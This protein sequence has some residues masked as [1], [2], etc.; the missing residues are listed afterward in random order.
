MNMITQIFKSSLGKKYI[1]AVTGFIL[2]LFV[3]GHLAGNLQI[4]LGREAINRYGHFLQS[5]PELIWPARIVLLLMVALHIWAAAKLSM[6]NKAARPVAYE[7]YVPTGSTYASRTMLMSGTIIFVFIIYHLLHFTVQTKAINGTGQDFR[8]FNEPGPAGAV[9]AAV[10]GAP[11]PGEKSAAQLGPHDI[12]K[13]MVIGF[14]VWWV[15]AFYI[16]GMGLLCLH[17]SHG[18]SSM[19]QSLGWKNDAYRPLLDKVARVVGAL[20]FLGYASIPVAIL[21]GYGSDALK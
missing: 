7:T 15:S 17:L 4:F 11:A 8:N 20:I 3:I 19:F 6:E 12:Y 9:A 5:N 2:F 21:L 10:G 13:M 14:R 18:A 16:L 1:M